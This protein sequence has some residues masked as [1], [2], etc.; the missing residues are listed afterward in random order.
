V[1]LR[2]A[3]D[4]LVNVLA[5]VDIAIIIVDAERRVRRFTP[6]A[7]S[8][9]KLIPSDIGRPISDLHTGV[10]VSR[11]DDAIAQVIETLVVHEAEVRHPDG[12]W[13]RMQIR[14]YRT[15][16]NKISGAVIAFVDITVLRAA[17]DYAAAIVDTIPT[18]LVVLDDQ[19]RVE[20]ANHAYYAAFATAPARV[21]GHALLELGEWR[22]PTL[23]DRLAAVVATGE[24][25]DGVELAY[26]GEVGER[27][28]R[29]SVRPL[30]SAAG[31]WILIGIADVTDLRRLE[32]ARDAAARER[33]T[34]LDVVSHELRT[35]LSAIL[36]WGEALRDLEHD[37]PR[38]IQAID[39]IT[40]SARAEAQ[41]VDD[42]LELA[43]SR[44][45][46]LSVN[47]EPVDPSPIV[48]A[49]IDLARHEADNKHIA[50]ETAL[51]TGSTIHADPRRLRQITSSLIG[52]AIKFT[53]GGGKVSV[54]LAVFDGSMELRVRDT[55]LGI[56]PEFLSRAF[57]PFSQADRSST[58]SHAG[59]GIGLALVRHF[60][61]R[62][63]GT[64]DV[65]S[66]GDG[67]GTIV[68]VRIPSAAIRVSASEHA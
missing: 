34:F 57:E 20:S 28:L 22:D 63:G 68:T 10:A 26:R 59:L 37:D 46:E 49:A 3:H 40:S 44:T 43:L 42:L 38:R 19:L 33:D 7:R 18:P 23:H 48:R 2:E 62:H 15:A 32:H 65:A 5:S 29:L 41:L 9:I 1:L 52:N 50:I 64:I 14:P 54:A 47:L 53:P 56:S 58:R 8:V 45:T 25:F 31:K 16:D 35:P 67:R 13:Y 61:E 6:K 21:T 51:A 36:L 27:V 11:F 24:G 66:P 30:P 17:H 4:D 39:T 12:T 55:G 60:V